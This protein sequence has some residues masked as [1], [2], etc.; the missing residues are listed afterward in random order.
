VSYGSI[1]PRHVAFSDCGYRGPA[2]VE[3]SCEPRKQ[4]QQQQQQQQEGGGGGGGG[5]EKEEEEEEEEEEK[6]KKNEM[7]IHTYTNNTA[8][9]CS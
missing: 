6:K 4:Q 8:I 7:V 3:G 2:D 5:G 9:V 1:S